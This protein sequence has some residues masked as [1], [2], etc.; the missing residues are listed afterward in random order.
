[1]TPKTCGATQLNNHMP[2][3]RAKAGLAAVKSRIREWTFETQGDLKN[4]TGKVKDENGRGVI[5]IRENE[6]YNQLSMLLDKSKYMKDEH[7]MRGLSWYLC[8]RLL[9]PMTAAEKEA[10]KKKK[11]VPIE[12]KE[13]RL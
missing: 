13:V 6:D 8:D 5:V 11:F 12:V 2:S 3:K 1:M 4:F 7:D 10:F 9:V